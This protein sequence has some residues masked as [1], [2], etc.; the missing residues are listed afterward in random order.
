MAIYTTEVAPDT[1]AIEETG[2]LI[3]S[4]KVVGSAVYDRKGEHLGS[5]YGLMMDKYTGRVAYVVV[6][7][8]PRHRRKLSSFALA[9]AA[10]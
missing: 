1:I 6:R 2:R 7:R 5:I 4:N 3:S 9:D 8:V 10:L